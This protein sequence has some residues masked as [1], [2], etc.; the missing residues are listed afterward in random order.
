MKR[1]K[2]TGI[3]LVSRDAPDDAVDFAEA[4]VFAPAET[5]GPR[6]SSA[7]RRSL[8]RVI[9]ELH[10]SEIN[11]GLQA[12]FD[13]GVRIWIGDELNGRAAEAALDKGDAAWNDDASLAHWL[14]ETALR[15][16]PGSGYAKRHRR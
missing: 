10:D 4:Q 7:P 8:Q 16:F 13:A 6:P 2:K 14:H 9:A 1:K 5:I 3:A 11:V 12:F 15:L